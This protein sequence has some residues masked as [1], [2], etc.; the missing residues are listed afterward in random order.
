MRFWAL[1][2]CCQSVP[3]VS[4]HLDYSCSN[5]CVVVSNC[6]FSM[7]FL[8]SAKTTHNYRVCSALLLMKLY[9]HWVGVSVDRWA[10][11]AVGQGAWEINAQVWM[12]L[13]PTPPMILNPRCQPDWIKTHSGESG[14]PC[15]HFCMSVGVFPDR[16]NWK[17]AHLE[18]EQHPW[19]GVLSWIQ[20]EEAGWVPTFISCPP[21]HIHLF[22]GALRY[23]QTAPHSCCHG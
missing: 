16:A 9:W 3:G 2:H 6:G 20:K 17:K 19:A 14:G 7:N 5:G 21:P 15:T 11:A 1:S 10:S 18:C 4:C 12:R 22:S 8:C 23:K 13:K